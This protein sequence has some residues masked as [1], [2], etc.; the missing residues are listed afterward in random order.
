MIIISKIQIFEFDKHYYTHKVWTSEHNSGAKIRS[1]QDVDVLDF[2]RV[3][4]HEGIR[5]KGCE[6]IDVLW[7]PGQNIIQRMNFNSFIGMISDIIV[8]SGFFTLIRCWH[9]E[10]TS[11]QM[12]VLMSTSSF[13]SRYLHELLSPT[14]TP[15]Y[16][17]IISRYHYWYQ[18]IRSESFHVDAFVS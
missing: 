3:M 6:D 8:A 13:K 12:S 1:W 2:E 17:K 16:S 7:R 9:L 11:I 14:Y 4:I 18:K 10:L 5:V 15:F